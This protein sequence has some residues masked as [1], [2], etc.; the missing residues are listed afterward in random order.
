MYIDISDMFVNIEVIINDYN[1]FNSNRSIA[2]IVRRNMAN[3][4]M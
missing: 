2:F 4:V 1:S 3:I